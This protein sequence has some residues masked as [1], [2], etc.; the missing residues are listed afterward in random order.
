MSPNGIA[1]VARLE[2][3][4][5]V[6]GARWFV[7]LVAWIAVIGGVTLLSWL[8]LRRSD[9]AELGATVYDVVL[10][11]VLGL[12]MLV[13]P[14]LTST[15]VNGDREHGVLATL[16]TTLLTPADIVL[17]KLLAAWLIA[18]AFL[19]TALPFLLFGFVKGGVD[20]LGAIRSLLVIAVVLAV[21]CAIGLMFSTLTARP[22]GSAVLTYLLV[23]G[24]GFLTTIVFTMSAFLVSGRE[25]VQVYGVDYSTVDET[26][27]ESMPP[28]ETYTASRQVVHTERIWWVLA[29][30]PFVIVA[31]AAPRG[32][33]DLVTGGFT[34]LRWISQG[35][36]YAKAGPQ[37]PVRECWSDAQPSGFEDIARRGGPVWPYGLGLMTL[38][39][40][41]ATAVAHQRVKTPVRRLPAGTRIA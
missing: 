16:Q 28:C 33:G 5:R 22:V 6:R 38:V 9:D 7:V 25:D 15:S 32:S 18:L 29:L 17:G 39:G 11:F 1:T 31:D 23:A 4:Q 19:A 36:R 40:V 10:F 3:M 30:N 26:T 12:A 20:V 14:A 2:L 21:V 27:A 37:E 35:V 41:G 34:P 13:M 24:L 8:G